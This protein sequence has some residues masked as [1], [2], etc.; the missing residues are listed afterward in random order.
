LH[1]KC[2]GLSP[3]SG[4]PKIAQRFKGCVKT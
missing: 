3:R 2:C 1:K 4:R